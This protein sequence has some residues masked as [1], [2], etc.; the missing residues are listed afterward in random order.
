[1]FT[2]LW[3]VATGHD[4]SILSCTAFN[5]GLSKSTAGAL[6]A[7]DFRQQARIIA[8]LSQ[9]AINRSPVGHADRHQASIG[10]TAR[11]QR[12][13]NRFRDLG[14]VTHA[15]VWDVALVIHP[16][17]MICE[18]REVLC[19][20]LPPS[21]VEVIDGAFQTGC[22]WNHAASWYSHDGCVKSFNATPR[23]F[24]HFAC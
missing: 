24:P 16:S 12:E 14:C 4:C 10:V 23:L 9:I 11:S 17:P 7:L 20:L 21:T 8:Q 3:I 18:F 2:V 19:P 5:G 1:M 22:R 13:R 15:L 6:L